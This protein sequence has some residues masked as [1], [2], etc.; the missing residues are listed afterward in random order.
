M[1]VA[2]A[3]NLRLEIFMHGEIIKFEIGMAKSKKNGIAFA[4]INTWQLRP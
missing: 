1:G 2:R 3:K 4:R